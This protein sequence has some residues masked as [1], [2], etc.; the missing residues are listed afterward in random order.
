MG[1]EPIACPTLVIH[2]LNTAVPHADVYLLSSVHAVAYAPQGA[3][4][5]TVGRQTEI[6]AQKVGLVCVRPF[7][8]DAASLMSYDM[9]ESAV[10]LGGAHLS[11]GTKKYLDKNNIES[12]AVYE[13]KPAQALPQP[14]EQAL[15]D[16]RLRAVLMFSARS[17]R[18][19]TDLALCATNKG[20]WQA[21][22]GLALSP[23]I[24][25]AMH[26]LPFARVRAAGAPNRNALLEMLSDDYE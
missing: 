18:V 23:R 15:E 3:K 2:S 5:M 22:E 1:Y 20:H 26:D 6:A 13:A 14:M 12:V 24:A 10:H 16:G 21:V 11:P 7:A 4:V 8:P 9:P 19:F 25:D 17:A